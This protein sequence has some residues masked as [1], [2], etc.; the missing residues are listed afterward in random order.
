MFLHLIYTLIEKHTPWTL[1]CIG[2]DDRR[3]TG[4]VSPGLVLYSNVILHRLIM[5]L[6][7]RQPKY[8]LMNHLWLVE[9][10]VYVTNRLF[11]VRKNHRRERRKPY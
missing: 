6:S 9:S 3:L 11:T 5:L 4:S 7:Y 10:I 1:K 8:V 2:F